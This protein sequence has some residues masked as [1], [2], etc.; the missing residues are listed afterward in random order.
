MGI[1]VIGSI[2]SGIPEAVIDQQ[3]GLLFPENSAADCAQKIL[4]AV[5]NWDKMLK[6]SKTGRKHYE[7]LFSRK[8][9]IKL[10]NNFSGPLSSFLKD[11]E[12]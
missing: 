1:P 11:L 5:K 3:T 4:W 12:A 8:R 6:Y 7:D 10:Q 2:H 9:K